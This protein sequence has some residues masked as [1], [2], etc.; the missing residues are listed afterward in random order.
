MIANEGQD[1]ETV[2]LYRD[3]EAMDASGVP[4][5]SLRVLQA[6]GAISSTKVPKAH[7]GY[8]RMWPESEVLKASIA[9]ALSEHFAWNIRIAAAV[10]ATVPERLW[11]DLIVTAALV[12][13]SDHVRAP[14]KRF[15]RA[16]KIDWAVQ[17]FD[18]KFVFL[19]IPNL[20]TATRPDAAPE[21]TE[22][23]L[24]I[25]G[26]NTFH[27]LPW[28]LGNREWRKT[29]QRKHGEEA[30]DKAFQR[31]RWAMAARANFLSMATI[32]I[33]MQVRATWRR[34]HGIESRFV[35][36]VFQIGKEDFEP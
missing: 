32:N 14:K 5:P 1:P 11:Q 36:E 10:M 25:V 12:A 7:G 21:Q 16:S 8:R 22:R 28:T 24:G 19:K 15:V 17:V 18:R 27:L 31:Y 33:S 29:A 20:M 34:L 23:L 6:A 26:E 3:K 35:Q 4:L 2:T 9:A 30:L 13:E